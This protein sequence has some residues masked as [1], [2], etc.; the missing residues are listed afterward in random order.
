V[1][2]TTDPG[3]RLDLGWLASSASRIL[4]NDDELRRKMLNLIRMSNPER[5]LKSLAPPSAARST[6][7]S[8]NNY[9]AQSI[10]KA[11]KGYAK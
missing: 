4:D 5:A 7:F 1:A 2:Q 8:L 6:R 3:S 10:T 11:T 9:P